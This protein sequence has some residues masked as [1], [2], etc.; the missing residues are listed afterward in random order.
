MWLPSSTPVKEYAVAVGPSVATGTPSRATVTRSSPEPKSPAV[1]AT[2]T[3]SVVSGAVGRAFSETN[4]ATV[5]TPNATSWTVVKPPRSATWSHTEWGP[6]GTRAKTYSV[7]VGSRFCSGPPSS[8][9]AIS[10]TPQPASEAVQATRTSA[11]F[12]NDPDAGDVIETRGASISTRIEFVSA[13]TFPPRSTARTSMSWGPFER[14]ERFVISVFAGRVSTVSPSSRTSKWSRPSP[15]SDDSHRTPVE[16]VPRTVPSVGARIVTVGGVLSGLK[17]R[18]P[19]S[20][21][22]RKY[23]YSGQAL[24]PSADMS[25]TP[26][27]A[28]LPPKNPI[29]L[30]GW[31][32]IR[33]KGIASSYMRWSAAL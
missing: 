8:E 29:V 13:P 16:F 22:F 32:L 28:W 4:G 10:P 11:V 2:S 33:A 18:S 17:I 21:S 23:P 3:R 31:T 1:Q 15:T 30:P 7:A 26:G 6:S 24:Y 27:D 9:I 20:T 25:Y 12:T 14:P 19:Y 5:S